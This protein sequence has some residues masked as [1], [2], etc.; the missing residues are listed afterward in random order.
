M[1]L[2]HLLD[3]SVLSQPIKDQPLPHVLE[4]WSALGDEAV[5]TSAICIA[6][7]LQGLESRASAKYWRRYRKLIQDRYRVLPFDADV[8]ATF[9]R[10]GAELS[11]QGTPRPALDL[12]IAATASHHG[13]VVATLNARD[14]GPISGVAVED[15]AAAD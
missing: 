11:R 7:I 2:T 9:A 13:L 12:M 6:E 14:F 8:A 3:T 5:C 4:R 1:P 15:W 10:L